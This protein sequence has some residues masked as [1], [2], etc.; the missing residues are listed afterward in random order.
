MNPGYNNIFFWSSRETKDFSNT[1]NM[2]GG[3]IMLM[4]KDKILKEKEEELR[5]MQEMVA[6]MQAQM[7]QAQLSEQI[8]T[9][10]NWWL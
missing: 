10:A 8:K 3:D 2:N 4:D 9:H 7:M 1:G 6:K 5:K